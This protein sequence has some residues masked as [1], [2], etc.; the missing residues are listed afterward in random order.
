MWFTPCSSSRSSVRL[1]SA[2]EPAPSAAAPKI[3]R[4]LS[5]PVLP[6]GGFAITTRTLPRAD[7]RVVERGVDERVVAPGHEVAERIP[8]VVE[9][10]HVREPERGA[11][12]EQTP[13]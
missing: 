9:Q 6:K 11:H 4:L 1:A 3:V 12:R 2:W 7:A 5:C 13:P 8:L 10:R